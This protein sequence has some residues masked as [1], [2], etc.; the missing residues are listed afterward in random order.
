MKIY[1]AGQMTGR[2]NYEKYFK[3]AEKELIKKGEQVF[4]P[5]NLLPIMQGFDYSDFMA[6]DLKIIELCDA[7]YFL[8]G[9]TKS[10]GAMQEY[11]HAKKHHKIILTEEPY[12]DLMDIGFD[13][14]WRFDR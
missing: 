11:R 8:K 13:N 6:V 12:E 2:K 10:K 4:N 14:E 7:V 1:I 3:K 9:F 5:C